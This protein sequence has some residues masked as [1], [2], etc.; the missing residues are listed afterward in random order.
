MCWQGVKFCR[1]ILVGKRQT[2]VSGVDA[3]DGVNSLKSARFSW[4][5]AISFPVEET[6]G[7][8]SLIS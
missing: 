1:F 2:K 3:A 8:W 4:A 7:P 5:R 6:S